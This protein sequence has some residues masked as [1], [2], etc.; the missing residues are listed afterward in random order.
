MKAMGVRVIA[1]SWAPALCAVALAG[2]AVAPPAPP[3][4]KRHTPAEIASYQLSQFSA[5]LASTDGAQQARAKALAGVAS[6]AANLATASE[7]AI[8]QALR[9]VAFYDTEHDAGRRLLRATLTDAS[10]PLPARPI[11]FQRAVLTAAHTFDAAGSAPL[12]AP[13][14]EQLSTPRQFAIAA[15]TLRRA[16]ASV[17]QRQQL[18][19]AL[20]RRTDRDDPRLLA[21]ARVLQEDASGQVPVRPPLVDLLAAPFKPG[22]PV[23][24]SLQRRD[25]R[26]LGLALVRGPDG[27]FERA[28]DGSLFHI[29]HLA[30]ALSGLPGTVTLGNTPQGLFTVVGT[31]T[32]LNPWIGP[33]PF[34]ESKI[35][36]EATPD[37]FAHSPTGPAGPTSPTSPTS[38][39]GPA[40]SPGSALPGGLAGSAEPAGRPGSAEPAGLAGSA[41]P[42]G[43]TAW[44]LALYDSWLPASWRGYAPMQEAWLAGLAGRDEMLAHGTAV[45]P[46]PYR[47]QSYFP[48]TPTDGC[49]MAQEVWSPTGQLLRSDQL[50]LARAFTRGGQDRG[51]LVVVELDDQPRAVTLQDVIDAVRAAELVT[52]DRH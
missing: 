23:V 16:D 21:L 49:L 9:A 37:E 1:N 30:L 43:I 26:H 45:D 25:R 28:A 32:A 18:Q 40:G 8:A 39:V 20:A 4:F 12:I 27:Q 11:D 31:G 44:S 19:D 47:G 38:S 5:P 33:T 15:Y 17:V 13:L 2:C 35:P 24:Y 14:L 34:L 51:H 52:I 7:D 48:G 6:A 3:T 10:R 42:A 36:T 50:A 46:T 22:L 29:P 41:E